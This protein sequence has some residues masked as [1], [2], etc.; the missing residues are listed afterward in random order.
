MD[1][2]RRLPPFADDALTV[3]TEAVGG[4][5]DERDG[6]AKADAKALLAEDDRYTESD[7]AHALDMLDNRGRIYYVDDQVRITPTD[8]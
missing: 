5:D 8:E 7:A 3:L 1:R 2:E 6:L 4:R